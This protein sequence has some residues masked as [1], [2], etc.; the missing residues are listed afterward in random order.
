VP[1][2]AAITL[3]DV[4]IELRRTD[5][6]LVKPTVEMADEPELDSAMDPRKAISQQPIGKQVDVPRQRALP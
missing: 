6:L 4:L 2:V 5:T 1:E 3:D